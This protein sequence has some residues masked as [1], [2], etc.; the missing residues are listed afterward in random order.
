[1][2]KVLRWRAGQ[3][4]VRPR[5]RFLPMKIRILLATVIVLGLGCAAYWHWRKTAPLKES[6]FLL[7]GEFANPSGDADFDGSLREALRVA[8]LQ[9]PYLNLISDERIRTT[10]GIMGKSEREPL[11]PELSQTLCERVGAKA[12]LTGR[13][14][15]TGAGYPFDME[16]R[17]C[18][19]GESVARE[20]G[21]AARRSGD[22]SARARCG[23][24]A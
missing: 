5:T 12:Y 23:Q 1:M 14:R 19:D 7:V 17:R 6:D 16:V 22:S 15:K 10:L 20:E 9:S 8:L 24:A 21:E 3:A 13:I 4:K 2:Q 18:P 11:T